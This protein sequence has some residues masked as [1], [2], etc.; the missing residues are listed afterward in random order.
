[1]VRPSMVADLTYRTKGPPDTSVTIDGDYK[2]TFAEIEGAPIGFDMADKSEKTIKIV[3]R[4]GKERREKTVT[5][6]PGKQP[7]A[8]EWN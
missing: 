4:L 2:G 3:M 8:L 5:I 1:M 6:Q 7:L